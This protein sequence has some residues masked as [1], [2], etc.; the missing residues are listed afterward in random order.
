M[1]S[2]AKL[3]SLICVANFRYVAHDDKPFSFFRIPFQFEMRLCHSSWLSSRNFFRGEQNLSLCN[4]LLFSDQ[5][6]GGANCLR[7]GAPH[8]RKPD[9]AF[10]HVSNS[11]LY[12]M[13]F[14]LLCLESRQLILKKSVQVDLQDR[15]E[16]Q[17]ETEILVEECEMTLDLVVAL[18]GQ[19]H[20][21]GVMDQG[22]VVRL[23]LKNQKGMMDE[24]VIGD[25]EIVI[26]VVPVENVS[27]VYTCNF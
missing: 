8:G 9:S 10:R 24:T 22:A 14:S 3:R 13:C 7:G 11:V 16:D 23:D 1:N 25:Q 4:F 15:V 2:T 27:G 5:I 26:G 17:G 6:S 20:Q 19:V 18:V 21:V 12:Q